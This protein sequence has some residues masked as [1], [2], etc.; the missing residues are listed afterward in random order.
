MKSNLY[1]AIAGM[2]IL[3]SCGTQPKINPEEYPKQLQEQLITASDGDVIELPEGRFEFNRQLSF[4]KTPNVTI[5]GAGKGKTVLSFKDQLE[6]GEGFLIKGANN[7]TL[8][9]FTVQDSKGDAIKVQDCTAVIMRDLEATWTAGKL[10]SNGGYGLYPVSCT[11]VLMENCEASYAMDAGIYVG[12]SNEVVVRNNLAHNNVAGIEIENTKNAEVYENTSRNNAGGLM[13]FDMPDLPVANG[14]NIVVHDNIIENN[15]GENFSSPGIVVNILPPGTGLLIMAHKRVDV[16]NNTIKDHNTVSVAI[17]SWH[18]TG[19]P[20][21]STDYDPFYHGLNIYD[22]KI[23]MGSG[24]ADNSTEFGRL[25]SSIS[26]GQPLGFVMDG[27]FN[28]EYFES[29][30][31]LKSSYAICFSNNGEIPFINLNAG[32]AMT[33]EGKLDPS[34]LSK[35]ISTDGSLFNCEHSKIE[36]TGHD[37]WLM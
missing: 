17:N 32:Q 1:P 6:G 19:R 30:G 5:K 36:L 4:N 23:E 25:L 3:I 22:N 9:G 10:A 20:F 13:I 26:Q 2:L 37:D 7:I 21:K 8:E 29:D 11:K 14:E 31:Q 28:P 24:S 18:F 16:F 12:Q 15:N 33:D 34:K 27:I 35:V